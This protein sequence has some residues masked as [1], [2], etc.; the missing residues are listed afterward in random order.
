MTQDEMKKIEAYLNRTM[1]R[2][3]FSLRSR[4]K[5]DDSC[6]VYLGDEFI[7]VVYK[8]DEDPS[9]ISYNLDIAILGEDL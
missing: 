1:G 8:D 6:E 5:V 4:G 9:D 2:E 7:G 3:G